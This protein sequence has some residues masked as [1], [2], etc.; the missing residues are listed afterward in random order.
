MPAVHDCA[1]PGPPSLEETDWNGVLTVPKEKVERPL[2]RRTASL[3]VRDRV[4]KTREGEKEKHIGDDGYISVRPNLS[5][6][7]GEASPSP[8]SATSQGRN[9]QS[10]LSWQERNQLIQE[11]DRHPYLKRLLEGLDVRNK[12]PFRETTSS[13]LRA[14]AHKRDAEGEER[15]TT[16]PP[17]TPPQQRLATVAEEEPQE[18]AVEI[19]GSTVPQVTLDPNANAMDALTEDDRAR[20]NGRRAAGED[21]DPLHLPPWMASKHSAV[22]PFRDG[23]T[24]TQRNELAKLKKTD[25]PKKWKISPRDRPLISP[26]GSP[27]SKGTPVAIPAAAPT[28]QDLQKIDH[29]LRHP[30]PSASG[31]RY[32]EALPSN[33]MPVPAGVPKYIKTSAGAPPSFGKRSPNLSPPLGRPMRSSN[34]SKAGAATGPA[35]SKK[36][37]KE[38]PL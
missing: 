36:V 34:L 33:E 10:S 20:A 23:M 18:G 28:I 30:H 27:G 31:F 12:E 16:T 38:K 5:E 15:A 19:M 37:R 29:H 6:E 3:M 13:R 32:E 25:S 9:S 21:G 7:M 11:S 14:K 8:K 2:D 17:L 1:A 26:Q 24:I 22:G 35:S 4:A